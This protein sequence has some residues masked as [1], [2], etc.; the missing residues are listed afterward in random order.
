VTRPVLL[1]VG[2]D[3]LINV[4]DL[5]DKVFVGLA[6]ERGGADAFP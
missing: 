1:G 2:L 4:V 6:A 3:G 5:P